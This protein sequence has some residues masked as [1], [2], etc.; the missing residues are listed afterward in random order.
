MPTYEYKCENCGK[1]LEIFQNMKDIPLRRCPHCIKN[2]LKRMLGTGAGIIFRGSGFFC[3]DYRSDGYKK[4]SEK[5]KNSLTENSLS[6]KKDT[7]AVSI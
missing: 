2:K 3:T 1:S 4:A 7:C 5:D 6:A